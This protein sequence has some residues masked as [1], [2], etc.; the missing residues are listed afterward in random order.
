MKMETL[1]GISFD[2][3]HLKKY[4]VR[5]VDLINIEG[6]LLTLFENFKTKE[7]FLFD[8]V[9][10][11]E[12][13]NRW[14]IYRCEPEMI[15]LFVDNKISHRDL[16]LHDQTQCYKVDIDVNLNWNNMETILKSDLPALYFP[17]R[18]IVFEEC[19][20]SD[21]EKLRLFIERTISLN[22]RRKLSGLTHESATHRLMIPY[23]GFK[24]AKVLASNKTKKHK[25]Q[26]I[27]SHTSTYCIV[28]KLTLKVDT[29]KLDT[30]VQ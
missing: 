20:C 4:L 26:N 28:N 11:D 5:I 17:D 24:V 13:S 7:L 25:I 10:S 6:P 23:V 21:T 2:L 18:S 19:D 12:L 16:F 15:L 27:V 8:W 14:L 1:K 9:D 22:K 29:K 3:G 30:Y